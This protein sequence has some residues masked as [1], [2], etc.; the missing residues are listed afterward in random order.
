MATVCLPF[1]N[2]QVSDLVICCTFKEIAL[3]EACW[4]IQTECSTYCVALNGNSATL[5][6]LS[7]LLPNVVMQQLLMGAAEAFYFIHNRSEQ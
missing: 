4:S 6:A 3:Y 7:S 2:F 1:L 5:R